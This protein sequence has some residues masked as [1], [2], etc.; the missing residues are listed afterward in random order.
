MARLSPSLRW[1]RW[2]CRLRRLTLRSTRGREPRGSPKASRTRGRFNPTGARDAVRPKAI[3]CKQQFHRAHL[4]HGDGRATSSSPRAAP[5]GSGTSSARTSV[6]SIGDRER[7][8][9]ADLLD[10]HDRRGC[11][12]ADRDAEEK[13]RGCDDPA[14]VRSSPSATASPFPRARA[15]RR[16]LDPREQEDL[17]VGGE[18]ERD[19]EEE[20]RRVSSSAPWRGSSGDPPAARPGRSRTRRPNAAESPSTFITSAFSG[21]TSDRVTAEQPE[22]DE[23]EQADRNGQVAHEARRR[24]QVPGRP[25]RDCDAR[26]T[27]NRADKCFRGRA[28]SPRRAGS[29]RSPRA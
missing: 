5:S 7:D 23:R 11:E 14:G 29:P 10:D 27:P 13:G 16:L 1:A 18:P 25:A 15:S 2:D 26:D 9:H 12:R 20:R 21:S 28:R 19:R 8:P 22:G 17:I 6:A 3:E 24:I 4:S